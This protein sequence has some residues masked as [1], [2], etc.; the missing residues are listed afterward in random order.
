MLKA[1][2]IALLVVAALAVAAPVYAAAS[3]C[4]PHACCKAVKTKIEVAKAGCCGPAACF[5][6]PTA[7]Q[8]NQKFETVSRISVVKLTTPVATAV[9]LARIAHP[10]HVDSAAAATPPSSRTRLAQLATLLI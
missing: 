6:A 1:T 9:T 7:D 2:A 4:G 8:A 5:E 3:A 10:S